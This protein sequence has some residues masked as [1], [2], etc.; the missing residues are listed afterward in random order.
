MDFVKTLLNDNLGYGVKESKREKIARLEKENKKLRDDNVTL[1]RSLCTKRKETSNG[2]TYKA[3]NIEI[4][5]LTTELEVAL[6]EVVRLESIVNKQKEMLSSAMA[7]I[8]ELEKGN[9]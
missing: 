7:R 2:K 5:A 6:E 4:E 9:K 3:K 1:K 8:A